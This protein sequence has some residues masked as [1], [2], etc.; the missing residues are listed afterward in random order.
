M[1]TTLL[2][3]AL[4][5]ALAQHGVIVP[6]NAS[7][8]DCMRQALREAPEVLTD[9]MG[10]TPSAPL[11]LH[12]VTLDPTKVVE[13]SDVPFTTLHRDSFTD[14][15]LFDGDVKVS[16]RTCA[17]SLTPRVEREGFCGPRTSRSSVGLDNI[18]R[19]PINRVAWRVVQ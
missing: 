4:I 19:Q 16:D 10:Y 1:S 18:I 5:A 11:N 9:V 14:I 12:A 15:V 3:A 13:I 6:D 7:A 8:D 2:T 17:H